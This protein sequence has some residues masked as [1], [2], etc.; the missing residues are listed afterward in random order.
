MSEKVDREER[1][2]YRDRREGKVGAGEVRR[3][4]R[5]KGFGV[6]GQEGVAKGVYMEGG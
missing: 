1:R 4:N 6:G 2:E 3:V 5:V